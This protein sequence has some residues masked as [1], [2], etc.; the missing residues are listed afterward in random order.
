MGIGQR[1]P[2]Q[3]IQVSVLI[4]STGKN[5]EY[6]HAVFNTWAD[7]SNPSGFRD[8]SNGQTQ[9]GQTKNFLIRFHFNRFLN[10]DWKINYDGKNWTIS[11]FQRIDEKKFYWLLT[12]T[13]KADV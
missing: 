8:Y 5:V 7:I 12:A 11:N 1:K 4:E 3:L 13:S 10:C 6:N 2:I 9:L